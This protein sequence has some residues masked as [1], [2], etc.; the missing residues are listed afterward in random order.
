MRLHVATHARR[1]RRQGLDERR[2]V[3]GLA[4]LRR[5][6]RRAEL[7]E[8][9]DVGRGV[10]A[11]LVGQVVLVEDRLDRAH[12]LAG[13]AVD[14]L[15]GVDVE[16]PAALVDA[17]DRTFLDAGL[18]Q[19][20]D[21]R[22]GDHVGHC[23]PPGRVESFSG[24]WRPLVCRSCWSLAGGSPGQ[25]AP[26]RR[27]TSGR[28]PA[29]RRRRR[30]PGRARRQRGGDRRAGN[31][32]VEVPIAQLIRSPG[33]LPPSTADELAL[34]A[35]AARGLAR[36]RDRPSSAAGCCA[37]TAASPAAPTRCCRCARRA[38][39]GRR[40][41]HGRARW[42][43]ERGPAAAH[44]RADRG[45]PAARRRA[46][47]SGAGRPTRDVH[48]MAARLD[49][50]A[51]GPTRRPRCRHRRRAGRR[52]ARAVPR[53]R[54]REPVG[55][56]AA[57]AGTTRAGFASVRAGGASRGDRA[58]RGRRRLARRHRRGGRSAAPPQRAGAARSWP[59]CCEWGRGAGRRP[60][61]PA[62]RAPTTPPALALYTRLG[63][64]HPPRL[65]LPHSNPAHDQLTTLTAC[66][67][68][69]GQQQ[70]ARHLLRGRACA[71]RSSCSPSAGLQQKDE[72]QL[73]DAVIISRDARGHSH[74]R[75][76]TDVT[77]GQAGVGAGVWGLLLGTLFGGPIGG[78]VVGA[79]SA[80]GGALFAKLVDTGVKD[81]TIERTAQDRAAGA[82]GGGAARQ[83]RVG[84]R[85]AA[86]AGPLP[87]TPSWSRPTCPPPR[88]R[89]VQNALAEAN[90]AP[91]TG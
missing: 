41:A 82:H 88:S 44:P 80:G 30:R 33:S 22:L 50:L 73:H 38:A 3:L 24:R 54:R 62:G 26:C 57:D 85:P 8:E 37:P 77:P 49:T 17:V 58:G 67:E 91:F 66:R 45:A 75:E 89:A 4:D 60:Q 87:A 18:V 81:E 79:A 34:E 15:V 35:V 5:A 64:W 46:W 40:A 51:I 43:A 74:V 11:P 10:V 90:R 19:E 25:R 65:P 48:V 86:R 63:Y 28:P 6:A 61:L 72:I 31:G 14:A 55:P 83:P 53:R 23:G 59:R 20:V 29:L 71:R 1:L 68:A 12:R 13:T 2:V 47:A 56:R 69:A 52:V 9:V 78:L 16:H 70:A 76:T 36:R 42:Y 84:G 39:A 21:A 7:V 27:R 32:P